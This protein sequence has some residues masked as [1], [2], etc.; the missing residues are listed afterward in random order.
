METPK[1]TRADD[2]YSQEEIDKML[3]VEAANA[4][5][6]ADLYSKQQEE[7]RNKRDRKSKAEQDL[8]AWQKTRSEQ[9]GLRRTNNV[10]QEK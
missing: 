2:D 7:E 10:E 3:Q 6:K 9:I 8:R 4:T 1:Q 5:R